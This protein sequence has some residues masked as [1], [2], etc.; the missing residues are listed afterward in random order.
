MRS[1][2]EISVSFDSV[3]G[4]DPHVFRSYLRIFHK[5]QDPEFLIISARLFTRLPSIPE[6]ATR[7]TF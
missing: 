6:T 7:K 5:D 3:R 4:A 2:S 1:P